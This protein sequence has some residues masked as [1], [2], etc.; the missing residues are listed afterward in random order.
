ML[1][2]VVNITKRLMTPTPALRNRIG[3]LSETANHP[4]SETAKGIIKKNYNKEDN[5]HIDKSSKTVIKKREG[6]L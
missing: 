4:I 1:L 6:Y 2:R 3:G 5:K